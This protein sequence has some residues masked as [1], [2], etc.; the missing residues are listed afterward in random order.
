M[1]ARSD[2]R[3][4]TAAHGSARQRTAAR[5]SAWQRTAAHGSAR[6]RTAARGARLGGKWLGEEGGG[7]TG[8]ST[9]RRSMLAPL[10]P[11]V[12]EKRGG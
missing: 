3:Q 6:Q 12:T 11:E 5:G 9:L 10:P 2:A 4:R 8:P 7:L 1:A